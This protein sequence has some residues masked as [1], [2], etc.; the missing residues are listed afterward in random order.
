MFV[1]SAEN[2]VE[3][4]DFGNI[5]LD[6]TLDC[7]QAFRWSKNNDGS[8]HGVVRGVETDVAVHNGALRFYNINEKQFY[9]V[10]YDYFDFGRDYDA[11][12]SQLKQDG[13]LAAA[14]EKYGTIRILRQEPWEALCSFIFSACNNIPRIKG[15][16]ERFCMNFGERAGDSFAFP[17]AEKTAELSLEELDVLRCGYRA[18]YIL[19]AAKMIS[20]GEIDL[21]KLKNED[22]EECEKQL[23]RINGV[24]KKVADCTI[25]FGLGH[26]DAFPVDRHIRRIC[27]NLYPDGLPECTKNYEGIAQQYMFHLQRMGE[28]E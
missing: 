13:H 25:L 2:F 9:D 28:A 21:E 22:I 1:K 27:E 19:S 26:V 17:S 24:G 20:S 7:G 14:I 10:F 11:I 5:N 4:S 3:V 8:W 23:T 15:I 6:V 12:L 18:P 16:I